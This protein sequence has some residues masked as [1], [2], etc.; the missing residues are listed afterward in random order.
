MNEIIIAM[1]SAN[2]AITRKASQSIQKCE[3]FRNQLQQE[4]E[5]Y[6]GQLKEISQVNYYTREIKNKKV[7]L[8]EKIKD[9]QTKLE[10]VKTMLLLTPGSWVRNG[11][12]KPGQ[13][14]DLKIAGKIPEVHVLWWNNTAPVPERPNRLKLIKPEDLEYVWDG[15]KFPKLLRRI[16]RFE[17]EDLA[18]LADNY[19]SCQ[20]SDDTAFQSERQLKIIYC[21]KRFNFVTKKLFPPG[22]RVEVNGLFGTTKDYPDIAP[23]GLIKVPVVL[24]G[25]ENGTL[26]VERSV[27][28]LELINLKQ[29]D[30]LIHQR[31]AV[32]EK[33]EQIIEAGLDLFYKVGQAFIEICTRKLYKD[34]GYSTFDE[35]CKQRWNMSRHY[36]YRLIKSSEVI[37]NVDNWQQNHNLANGQQNLPTS[38]SQTRELAKL[39]VEQ[40]G[41]A[42]QKTVDSASDGKITANHV[43][44]V[45]NQMKDNNNNSTDKAKAL[46]IGCLDKPL[47]IE[48]FQVG[49]IVVISTDSERSDRRL[50]G[51]KNSYALITAVNPAS[52]DLKLFGQFLSAV[53]PNDIK[54]LDEFYQPSFC[55][56]VSQDDMT[57]LL[58]E[59]NSPEDIVRCALAARSLN[60]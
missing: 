28:P 7:W 47:L 14:V 10:E 23:E 60:L 54:P 48:Q 16:D 45:V 46:Q 41:E 34:L 42:W 8:E 25:D 49:Q 33:L 32:M 43:K 6:Q 3:A 18:V 22:I 4:I 9:Y 5:D 56:S 40:Q 24:D 44:A 57:K 38:E 37:E 35:Y 53:S 12:T 21:L 29:Q 36:A 30:D 15:G 58:D 17:C 50:V 1:N 39:P 27:S 59:F 20:S 11:S 19:Q 52:V 26:F 2:L 13:I 31:K 51:L 55:I